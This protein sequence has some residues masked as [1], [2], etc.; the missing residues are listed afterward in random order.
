MKRRHG[1]W[2]VAWRE[3]PGERLTNA[4]EADDPQREL[5]ESPRA[6]PDRIDLA[7][8]VEPAAVM[9][10]EI[11]WRD[12]PLDREQKRERVVRHFLDRGVR[13]VSDDDSQA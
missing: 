3:L 11:E 9:H 8:I 12:R 6:G 4:P 1:R 13:H 10:G 5:S 7:G 2:P